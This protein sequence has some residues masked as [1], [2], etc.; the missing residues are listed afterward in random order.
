MEKVQKCEVQEQSYLYDFTDK[1]SSLSP[2]CQSLSV[3]VYRPGY[4]CKTVILQET[5]ETWFYLISLPLSLPKRFGSEQILLNATVTDIII[6][7]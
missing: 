7:D 3:R 2:S 4:T 1:L 5:L 6:I